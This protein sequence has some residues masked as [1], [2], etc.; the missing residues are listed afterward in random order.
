MAQPLRNA[1][2]SISG[3]STN[4]P[5]HG[6]DDFEK[7]VGFGSFLVRQ[8]STIE[9]SPRYASVR[10]PIGREQ[11]LVRSIGFGHFPPWWVDRLAVAGLGDQPTFCRDALQDSV[12]KCFRC[13]ERIRLA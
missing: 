3:F 6:C 7:C 13:R 9:P 5:D 8:S 2:F 12:N 11:L 10:C 4:K 1:L